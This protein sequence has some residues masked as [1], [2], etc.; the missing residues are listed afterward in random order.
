MIW[1]LKFASEF[2][3]RVR[4]RIRI[5]I[6]SCI[7]ATA[8]HSGG[9]FTASGKHNPYRAT[10]N[11][12]T[13]FLLKWC[14]RKVGPTNSRLVSRTKK[15]HKHLIHKFFLPPFVPG[16]S[17]GKTQFVGKNP[18]CPWDKLG[19]HCVN[20]K[21]TWVCP[22]DSPGLSQG[23]PGSVPGTNWGSSQGQPDQKIYVYVPF[24][25]PDCKQTC[26]LNGAFFQPTWLPGVCDDDLVQLS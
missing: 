23:Q 2:S 8:V 18:V 15:A 17:Q 20:K 1:W 14:Y 19:F 16:L 10:G 6:R 25:L 22:R 11:Q 26:K 3:G 21:K 12:V 5:R 7:A 24:F 4:I 9:H 13:T